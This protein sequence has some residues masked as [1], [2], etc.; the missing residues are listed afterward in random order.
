LFLWLT[1]FPNFGCGTR[2]TVLTTIVLFMALETTS[3]VR[4]FREPRVT[5][6][7]SGGG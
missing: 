6:A 5:D 3:P 7:G 2:V 1:I 4:V